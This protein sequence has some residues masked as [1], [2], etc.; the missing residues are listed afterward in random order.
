MM[1]RSFILPRSI[2][3]AARTPSSFDH[4][5]LF[6]DMF[7]VQEDSLTCGQLDVEHAVMRFS[8][9]YAS[10]HTSELF[11]DHLKVGA[12]GVYVRSMRSFRCGWPFMHYEIVYLV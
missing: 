10:R 4:Q 8:F 2:G 9:P 5:G 7:V 11:R 6:S 12:T 3:A 1:A